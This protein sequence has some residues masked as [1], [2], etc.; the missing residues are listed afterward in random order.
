MNAVHFPG[1]LL[2]ATLATAFF[3]SDCGISHADLIN[4]GNT[5]FADTLEDDTVGSDPSS[6]AGLVSLASFGTGSRTRVR[7]DPAGGTNQVLLSNP[8]DIAGTTG[9]RYRFS[10]AMAANQPDVGNFS[11]RV[12]LDQIDTGYTNTSAP[13]SLLDVVK[14]DN[15]ST[16]TSNMA[17]SLKLEAVN[18]KFLFVTSGQTIDIGESLVENEWIDVSID[19]DLTSVTDN[20]TLS[21][22]STSLNFTDT[23]SSDLTGLVAA[24]I[25][26]F[27]LF[28]RAGSSGVGGVGHNIFAIDD[29]NW[30]ATAVPEPTSLALGSLAAL[31]ASLSSGSRRKRA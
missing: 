12:Y 20:L 29:I 3:A 25:R 10:P 28:N 13:T 4:V 22:N 18:N 9:K 31:L 5:Y 6:T 2:M 24:P 7:L 30:T 27:W 14:V 1:R 23:Y 17:F 21:L 11:Y 16:G 19:Y 15:G 26:T 8:S